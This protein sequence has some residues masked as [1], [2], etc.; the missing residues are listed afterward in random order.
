[1][2]QIENAGFQTSSKTLLHPLT[3][4][5]ER[6][7]FYGL[8]GHN[9]SGKSTL[10]KLLAR[11]HSPSQGAILLDNTRIDTLSN[12]EYARKLAYL[13]Q[14]TPVIPDM[15]ARELVELG[16]YSWNSI[17]RNNNP[18]NG[19]AVARAIEL[20]DTEDF[21][22]A[23][24]DSLS[25]GERQRVAIARALIRQRPILLLDEAFASLGPALRHQMLDLVRE[26]QLETGMTVLMVTHTPEDALYLDAVLLFL[27][28]GRI[29]A[30]GPSAELLSPTGPEALRH[31]IGEKRSSGLSLK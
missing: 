6:G 26:L 19:S 27:D 11:E 4:Q 17:W 21:M 30:M 23:L 28:S 8:I 10:L 25:G 7:K 3:T 14:Y 29:S 24:L 2:I 5:F 18:D 16:R 1:M 9:G 15:S 31:Y 22:P 13:P 20:T 12:R